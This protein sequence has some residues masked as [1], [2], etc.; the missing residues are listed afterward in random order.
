MAQMAYKNG[1]EVVIGKPVGVGHSVPKKPFESSHDTIELETFQFAEVLHAHC[2][3]RTSFL[4]ENEIQFD[5][6]LPALIERPFAMAAYAMAETVS[7]ESSVDCYYL[8]RHDNAPSKPPLPAVAG[9]KPLAVVWA[10]FKAAS[11]GKT[12]AAKRQVLKARYWNRIL[13]SDLV[14]E[15]RK[16]TSTDTRLNFV[17]D[18]NRLIGAHNP[19]PYLKDISAQARVF[20]FLAQTGRPGALQAYIDMTDKGA[21]KPA[22]KSATTR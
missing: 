13:T 8:V 11:N 20:L 22:K 5:A 3:Y 15:F 14:S 7:V 12:P 21:S 9:S 4:R 17:A 6:S 2:L 1:S 19:D 18:L 10:T 16:Q